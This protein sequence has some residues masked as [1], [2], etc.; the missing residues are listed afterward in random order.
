MG[1]GFAKGIHCGRHGQPGDLVLA[2]AIVVAV[3]GDAISQAFRV[4]TVTREGRE[5]GACVVDMDL[6]KCASSV[7]HGHVGAELAEQLEAVAGSGG[8]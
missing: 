8:L 4:S 2:V 5:E 3:S 1:D 6:L 7:G